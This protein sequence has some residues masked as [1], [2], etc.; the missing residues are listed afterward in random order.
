MKPGCGYLS[1]ISKEWPI[2]RQ[3]EVLKDVHDLYVD[4]LTKSQLKRRL[5]NELPERIMLLRPT[6]RTVGRVIY[7]AAW[8]CFAWNTTDLLLAL[9]A[10][11]VR[12]D[13]V[14]CLEDGTEVAPSP[15]TAQ[16][17]LVVESF[18]RGK[19]R[20]Q[21]GPARDS[22]TW[23]SQQV[24]AADIARRIA[25]IADDWPKPNAEVTTPDLMARAGGKKSPMSYG[26]A[27]KFLKPRPHMQRLY[28]VKL[29]RAAA[30]GALKYE[31]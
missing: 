8:A 21:T 29:E 9:G 11:A 10:A 2:D 18:M 13:T 20:A 25:L 28:Q 27:S 5:A 14:V 4:E 1:N 15:N 17:G 3:R 16:I 23:S 30:R 6:S 31:N 26:T 19:K 12:L 24:R 22:G 7:V